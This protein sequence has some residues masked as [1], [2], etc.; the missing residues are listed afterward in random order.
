MF[1]PPQ[2]PY[3]RPQSGAGPTLPPGTR[4]LPGPR[5]LPPHGRTL[6]PQ[7]PGTL[8]PQGPGTWWA[9]GPVRPAARKTG[10]ASALAAVFWSVTVLS[11]GWLVF[12]ALNISF[13]AAIAGGN[14][15]PYFLFPAGGLAAVIAVVA[16]MNAFL[17]A[18]GLP[19]QVK[20]AALG[21]VAFPGPLAGV[22]YTL[23]WLSS[24]T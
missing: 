20:L 2:H 1:G 6:P 3:S 21:A 10:T 9:P 16:V 24:A 4:T 23:Y 15:L 17:T 7:G 14:P 18:K 12:C 13:W 8:P 5:T 19:R 11:L 22:L